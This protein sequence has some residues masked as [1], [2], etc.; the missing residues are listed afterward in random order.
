MRE[1][2]ALAKSKVAYHKAVINKAA[3]IKKA[4]YGSPAPNT[5]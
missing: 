3:N 4:A 5:A 2:K 1:S